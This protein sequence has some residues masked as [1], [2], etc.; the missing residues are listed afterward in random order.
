MPN[1]DPQPP[2]FRV[3]TLTLGPLDTNC[4]LLADA[5]SGEAEAI[6]P[7]DDAP[8]ILRLARREG[9][10]IRHILLTHGHFDHAA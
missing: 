5:E 1:Y 7:A 9:W 2:V 3:A 4:Y 8:A 6:D 10:S